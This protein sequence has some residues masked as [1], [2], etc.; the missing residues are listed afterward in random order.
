MLCKSG[1]RATA[2]MT[3]LRR[4]G[5]EDTY[6]LKGGLQALTRYMGPKEANML[7]GPKTAAR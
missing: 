5:F 4:I 6:V 3:A 7:L 1:T 2:A